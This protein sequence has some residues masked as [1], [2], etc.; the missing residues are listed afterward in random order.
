MERNKL[1]E[2][3]EISQEEGTY[4]LYPEFAQEV[5]KFQ[6]KDLENHQRLGGTRLT[7]LV[8][9]GNDGSPFVAK[10]ERPED[11]HYRQ[12]LQ[13]QGKNLS[14]WE[15]SIARALSKLATFEDK[16]TFVRFEEPYGLHVDPQGRRTSLFK[17]I[18][19]LSTAPRIEDI[20]GSV[21]NKLM[22]SEKQYSDKNC[23]Y[24]RSNDYSWLRYKVWDFYHPSSLAQIIMGVNGIRHNEI[25]G[26]D[27]A[28]VSPLTGKSGVHVYDFELALTI[29]T[30]EIT[31]C[32][33]SQINHLFNIDERKRRRSNPIFKDLEKDIIDETKRLTDPDPI[34]ANELSVQMGEMMEKI[35]LVLPEGFFNQE[36]TFGPAYS[37]IKAIPKTI[38]G[39]IA[40]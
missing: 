10:I 17:F 21:P 6:L 27:A 7:Y 36:E 38:D 1:L 9:P 19:E 28:Y 26:R 25:I 8:K 22:I 5:D 13:C 39:L 37:I 29:H 33:L 31:K 3:V 23:S 4:Y 11:D 16:S 2:L 34:T 14:I 12:K 30:S 15:L 35:K 20:P 40:R 24:E 18:P 32:I